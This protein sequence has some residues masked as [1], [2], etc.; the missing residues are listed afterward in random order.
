MFLKRLTRKLSMTSIKDTMS[1]INDCY[2]KKI[3]QTL[4]TYC[5][6]VPER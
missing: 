4:T 1:E 3:Q 6:P 2:F 5:L